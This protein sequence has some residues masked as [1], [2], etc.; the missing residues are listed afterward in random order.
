MQ[1]KAVSV[2]GGFLLYGLIMAFI[3]FIIFR[4][5]MFYIGTINAAGAGI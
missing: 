4:I 5:A 3:V 2:I 1:L